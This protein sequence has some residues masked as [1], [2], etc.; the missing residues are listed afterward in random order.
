[1]GFIRIILP[2]IK[3]VHVTHV[4]GF[5]L[6][7]LQTHYCLPL[8]TQYFVSFFSRW[9]TQFDYHYVKCFYDVSIFCQGTASHCSAVTCTCSEVW[10]MKAR[11]QRIISHGKHRTKT[12]LPLGSIYWPSVKKKCILII[13]LL[14]DTW[15]TCMFWSFVQTQMHWVGTCHKPL[16][17]HHRRVNHTLVLGSRTKMASDLN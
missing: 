5:S 3:C 14:T 8:Y 4:C 7:F 1:M 2:E 6:F 11:T 13:Y 12:S 10:P 9:A 16:A 17:W 15:T